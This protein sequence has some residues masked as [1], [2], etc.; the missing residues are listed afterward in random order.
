MSRKSA[1]R[2]PLLEVLDQFRRTPPA[3][4]PAQKGQTAWP[5]PPSRRS[6][7]ALT[8]WQDAAALKQLKQL[9]DEQGI[10]QQRAL[11][12]A[13]NLLFAKHGKPPIAN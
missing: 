1:D 7:K 12:E 5:I 9:A 8:T 4:A 10:S 3:H 13:L 2:N 6:K 11:A